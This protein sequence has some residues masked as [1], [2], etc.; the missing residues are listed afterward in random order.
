MFPLPY[1]YTAWKSGTESVTCLY[2]WGA[3][4][5]LVSNFVYLYL[6]Y[7]VTTWV[8]LIGQLQVSI[9]DRD[10]LQVL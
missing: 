1:L 5:L 9:C 4:V 7:S 3:Y 6:E 10:L 2:V 8:H